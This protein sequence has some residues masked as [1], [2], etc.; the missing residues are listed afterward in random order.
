MHSADRG[1][2]CRRDLRDIDAE[3]MADGRAPQ[4]VTVQPFT[5][6]DVRCT[7]DPLTGRAAERLRLNPRKSWW[8]NV[9]EIA[10]DSPAEA[11][12]VLK[13]LQPLIRPL[14]ASGYA[15]VYP[16]PCFAAR[17]AAAPDRF[18]EF[19][20]DESIRLVRNPDRKPGRPCLDGIEYTIIPNRSTAILAFTAG[21]FDL[22]F[23]YEVTVPLMKDVKSQA[24]QA[25]FELV[26]S[27][28][29]TNLLVNREAAPN[30]QP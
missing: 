24:S 2:R 25:V 12:F 19:K 11:T 21:K 3:D 5:L 27:N 6:A 4:D 1:G 23:P 30:R 8:N 10:T 13:R 22:T 29:S 20:P 17:Y 15:P 18:V 26:P 14:I 28:A 7:W 9:A 16:L